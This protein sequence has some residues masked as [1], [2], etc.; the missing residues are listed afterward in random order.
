MLAF[1]PGTLS[2]KQ[3]PTY[4]FL[5]ALVTALAPPPKK[6]PCEMSKYFLPLEKIFGEK[7]E[8][9]KCFKI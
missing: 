7:L 5:L 9:P 1:L 8:T 2:L 4:H 6:A 3:F